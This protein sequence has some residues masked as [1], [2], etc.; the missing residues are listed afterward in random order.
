M[1][2]YTTT[3]SK[4]GDPIL[5]SSLYVREDTAVSDPDEKA[6][7]FFDEKYPSNIADK[8]LTGKDLKGAYIYYKTGTEE[9]EEVADTS[10]ETEVSTEEIEE[11]AT[12]AVET[13]APSGEEAPHETAVFAWPGMLWILLVILVIA[14]GAAGA[15]VYYRK[16]K[17]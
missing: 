8:T 14:G 5:A 1:A 11:T 9:P 3:S 6:F 15:G 2:I 10:E 17:K 4:V 12:A 16:R 13:A 7:S